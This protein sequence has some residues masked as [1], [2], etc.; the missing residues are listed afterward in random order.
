[1]TSWGD[2]CGDDSIGSRPFDT[3]GP[4]QSSS[5]SSSNCLLE[6]WHASV[7][8]SGTSWKKQQRSSKLMTGRLTF[9]ASFSFHNCELLTCF[10]NVSDVK[11]GVGELEVG[12]AVIWRAAVGDAVTMVVVDGTAGVVGMCSVLINVLMTVVGNCGV[13]V[14]WGAWG[15]FQVKFWT[16]I[17]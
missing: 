14:L 4:W 16:G 6:R 7:T 12:T 13:T 1:M 9:F 10:I 3:T 8:K 2:K 15:C 17:P 5:I 11:D